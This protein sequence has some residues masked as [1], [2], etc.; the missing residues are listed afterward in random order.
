MANQVQ[1]LRAAEALRKREEARA[2][3][4][5]E[6]REQIERGKA[7]RAVRLQLAKV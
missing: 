2:I 7:E 4:R 6:A 3:A 5:A 1:A